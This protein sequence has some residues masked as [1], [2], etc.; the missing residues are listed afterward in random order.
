MAELRDCSLRTE[1]SLQKLLGG[2]DRLLVPRPAPALADLSSKEEA[3]GQ[4]GEPAGD[5]PA[6]QAVAS[7]NAADGLEFGGEPLPESLLAPESS[8][9]EAPR[10]PVAPELQ[11]RPRRWSLFG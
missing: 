9:E 5:S 10:D 7:G 6:Q 2:L 3:I 1:Q 4:D 11:P 8:A